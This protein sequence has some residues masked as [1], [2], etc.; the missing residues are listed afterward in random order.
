MSQLLADGGCEAVPALSCRQALIHSRELNLSVDLVI[1]N[2]GLPNVAEML[3]ALV[4][5]N[6][7][8][9]V[10]FIRN[11]GANVPGTIHPDAVLERPQEWEARSWKEWLGRIQ[12]L[13]IDS[14]GSRG[15]KVVLST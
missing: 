5:A 11:P 4:H 14:S 7:Q 12:K 9:R 8:L 10:V 15:P 3:Q 6:S 2:S 1:V 13:L